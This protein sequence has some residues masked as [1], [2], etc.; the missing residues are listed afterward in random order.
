MM[1]GGLENGYYDGTGQWQ[2]TKYCFADCGALCDCGPPLGVQ[3]NVT[4]D[5]R[6]INT[7]GYV[8]GPVKLP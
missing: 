8:T 2:R 7:A 1:L 3:Y 4:F 5:K 6:Y